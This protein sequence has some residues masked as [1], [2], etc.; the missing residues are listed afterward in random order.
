[1]SS[2]T[3]KAVVKKRTRYS[4]TGWSLLNHSL[5]AMTLRRRKTNRVWFA[6]FASPSFASYLQ[7]YSSRR[8]VKK[9]ADFSLSSFAEKSTVHHRLSTIVYRSSVFLAVKHFYIVKN[10]KKNQTY[11]LIFLLSRSARVPS[12][13]SGKFNST[14]SLQIESVNLTFLKLLFVLWKFCVV[15]ENARASLHNVE[16]LPTNTQRCHPTKIDL[17]I[18]QPQFT[19]VFCNGISH[20]RFFLY[21]RT[22]RIGLIGDDTRYPVCCRGVEY[23][24]VRIRR[25]C[26]L[27]KYYV[28]YNWVDCERHCD[29]SNIFEADWTNLHGCLWIFEDEGPKGSQLKSGNIDRRV[30]KK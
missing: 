5:T 22:C 1:M 16:F 6:S 17:K 19:C 2:T 3:K 10:N 9:D 12:K 11:E 27:L 4:W 24:E 26:C 15:Y 29:K 13:R 21:L 14:I 30:K 25:H 7:R 18:R 28:S 23:R 8:N 20:G